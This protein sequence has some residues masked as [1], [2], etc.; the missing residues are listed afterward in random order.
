MFRK[1][2]MERTHWSEGERSGT[3][4]VDHILWCVEWIERTHSIAD[5]G[6]SRASEASAWNVE[7]T[8]TERRGNVVGVQEHNE[9]HCSHT[10]DDVLIRTTTY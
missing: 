4:I 1:H 8:Y 10:S 3:Q 2:A 6:I 9:E 5:S 7:G